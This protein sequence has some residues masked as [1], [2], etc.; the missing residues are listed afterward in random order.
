MSSARVETGLRHSTLACIPAFRLDVRH[1]QVWLTEF[2]SRGSTASLQDAF[3]PLDRVLLPLPEFEEKI[4]KKVEGSCI[5][6][7]KTRQFREKVR[8]SACARSGA[9]SETL[10]RDLTND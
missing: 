2:W 10:L 4:A 7:P 6:D 5:D 1:V 9:D 8:D 3:A